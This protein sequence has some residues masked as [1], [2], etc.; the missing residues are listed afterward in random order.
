MP[1]AAWALQV[2]SVLPVLRSL[3]NLDTFRMTRELRFGPGVLIDL[4]PQIVT[5]LAVWPLT[6]FLKS[7]V[8][9]VW[10][11]LAKQTASTVASHFIA[12][13]KYAWAF[14]WKVVKKIF[15]FGWPMLVNGFLMFGIHA[16]GPVRRGHQ[17]LRD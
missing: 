2:L 6:Q 16:G 8:V 10:L 9:L 15:V 4:V 11:A 1:E 14:D 7:Y 13:R 12:E 17:I 3:S 5:T